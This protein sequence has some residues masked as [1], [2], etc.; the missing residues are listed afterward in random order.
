MLMEGF[1]LMLLGMVMVFIVLTLL[2]IVVQSSARFFDHFSKYF[3][4]PA[5]PDTHSS[6]A[7][8]GN[9][10]QEIAVVLAAIRAQMH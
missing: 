10:L 1:Q 5:P 6:K 9:E 3:P 4:D 8:G 7:G 2:V